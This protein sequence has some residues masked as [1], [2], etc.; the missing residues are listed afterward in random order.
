M[1]FAKSPGSPAAS[2]SFSDAAKQATLT[3]GR[4]PAAVKIRFIRGRA[5]AVV[6]SMS[7]VSPLIQGG[8]V[9]QEGFSWEDL[10]TM[11]GFKLSCSCPTV[12]NS[13]ELERM[14]SL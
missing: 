13:R 1:S 4:K 6:Y 10:F 7:R 2:A 8:L 9:A 14:L 11:F 3:I 12:C 5:F